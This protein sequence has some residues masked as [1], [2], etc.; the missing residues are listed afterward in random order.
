THLHLYTPTLYDIK[1][2]S[3]TSNFCF[4]TLSFFFHQEKVQKE[5]LPLFVFYY[6][7]FSFF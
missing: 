7:L 1:Y 6:N 2:L 4:H 5:T 3:G